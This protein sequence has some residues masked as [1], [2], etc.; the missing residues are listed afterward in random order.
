MADT[1]AQPRG[2]SRRSKVDRPS[3]TSLKSGLAGRGTRLASFANLAVVRILEDPR[4][5]HAAA[6]VRCSARPSRA[7]QQVGQAGPC[8][9]SSR[10]QTHTG[11]MAIGSKAVA[12]TAVAV[13]LASRL[14]G[15]THEPRGQ[16]TAG[17][18][19]GHWAPGAAVVQQ[20]AWIPTVTPGGQVTAGFVITTG[21][22]ILSVQ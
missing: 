1:S 15:H 5:P 13:A 18:L 14:C 6:S 20:S 2:T 22:G 8:C 3:E 17:R 12:A 19:Q 10:S 7:K 11:R 9:H 16:R 21:C 4:E